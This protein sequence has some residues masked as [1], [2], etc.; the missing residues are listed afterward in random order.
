MTNGISNPGMTDE[1]QKGKP[2]PKSQSK[3]V[4]SRLWPKPANPET[5]RAIAARA[6]DNE[7]TASRRHMCSDLM[8][9]KACGSKQC[10]RMHVCT[11]D[12]DACFNRLWPLLPEEVKITIRATA[13]ALKN[14]LSKPEILAEVARDL[15]RWREVAALQA[16]TKPT[17]APYTQRNYAPSS[18]APSSDAPKSISP[19]SVAARPRTSSRRVPGPKVRVL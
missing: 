6:G 13:R 2:M 8:F 19:S 16:A 10:L 5:L 9:W 14:R 3:S 7:Q 1:I 17:R 12:A 11:G 15:A 18:D 4:R